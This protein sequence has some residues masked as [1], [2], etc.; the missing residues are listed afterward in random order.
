[1]MRYAA[2]LTAFA[3]S[4]VIAAGAAT[5]HDRD[6]FRFR[7]GFVSQHQFVHP[8]FF[9]DRFFFHDPVF[10][11]DR[12]FF[13]DRVFFRNSFFFSFSTFGAPVFPPPVFPG[14]VVLAPPVSSPVFLMAP[15]PRQGNCREFQATVVVNGQPQPVFGTACLGADGAWHIVP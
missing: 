13:R 6:G 12:F 2:G 15:V 5:A 1:M 11:H 7:N 10:F 9:H 3:L 14:P 4:S 8:F